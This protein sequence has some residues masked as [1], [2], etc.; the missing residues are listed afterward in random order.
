MVVL[1]SGE[2]GKAE[3]REGFHRA[4]WRKEL[5]HVIRVTHEE[6]RSELKSMRMRT[7]KPNLRNNKKT[8][9]VMTRN[10]S[11]LEL[12]QRSDYQ[13]MSSHVLADTDKR[14]LITPVR[15]FVSLQAHS[16]Q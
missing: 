6:I 11:A 8:L 3:L 15:R 1:S 14:C 2:Q 10:L 16:S 4:G 9:S 7:C 12:A 5:A 13:R